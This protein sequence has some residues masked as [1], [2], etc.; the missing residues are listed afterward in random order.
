MQSP[1]AFL[2]LIIPLALVTM[3]SSCE[4]HL[5]SASGCG[6][7]E[8]ASFEVAPGMTTDGTLYLPFH[9]TRNVQVRLPGT[10]DGGS[11]PHQVGVS[12]RLGNCEQ[13]T[14]E[15]R[16]ACLLHV[17]AGLWATPGTYSFNLVGESD[18]LSCT[19]YFTVVVTDL[20]AD[21]GP[22][23]EVHGTVTPNIYWVPQ[24]RSTQ[25][26]VSF[27]SASYILDVLD[28][29]DLDAPQTSVTVRYQAPTGSRDG[30]APDALTITARR[31]A[32]LGTYRFQLAGMAGHVHGTTDV[33]EVHVI[34]P[35]DAAVPELDAAMHDANVEP[36]SDAS[37]D[38][39]MEAGSD[40][41]PSTDASATTHTLSIYDGLAGGSGNVSGDVGGLDCHLYGS[42]VGSGVCEVTLPHGTLI[43]LTATPSGGASVGAWN[44]TGGGT[45]CSGTTCAIVLNND[46][47]VSVGFGQGAVIESFTATPSATASGGSSQLAWS[48]RGVDSCTIEPGTINAVRPSGYQPVYPTDTT[49]YTL[50]CESSAG[51][52][53]ATTTVSIIANDPPVG[54]I[55]TPASNVTIE[56]GDAITFAGNCTDDDAGGSDK[57][58]AWNFGSGADP[59]WAWQ[60]DNNAV[61]YTTV[62]VY[63][64]TYDCTD[65]LGTTNTVQ[66]HVTVTVTAPAFAHVVGSDQHTCGLTISGKIYCWGTNFR[67]QLG[68]PYAVSGSNRPVQVG[69]RDQWVQLDVGSGLSC[70]IDE[71]HAL[72]C[73]G[74]FE[75]G[76][77]I[78]DGIGTGSDAPR[79]IDL[80]TDWQTISVGDSH[81]CAT[82]TNGS[83]HCWGANVYGEVG[84]GDQDQRMTFTQVG[85]D[86]D[87]V[88]VSTGGYL[89]C[90][91]K[92][93]NRAYCWGFNTYYG[94]GD[95]TTM[96]RTS[97][98]EIGS[99]IDWATISASGNF[100]CGTSVTHDLYCWGDDSFGQLGD[101]T[102][103]LPRTSTPTRVGTAS[104]WQSV[105]AGYSHTC[106]LKTSGEILCWGNNAFGQ[107]GRGDHIESPTPLQVESQSDWLSIEANNGHTCGT[108]D[109]GHAYCWGRNSL[110]T[111]G[112]GTTNESTRPTSIQ[113]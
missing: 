27:P 21:A 78:G 76:L 2:L 14:A 5:P 71:L 67:G 37:T 91:I 24:G 13:Q 100:A 44:V 35:L 43:T 55:V 64:V 92:G 58:H 113:P 33:F 70:A 75:G 68:Q 8:P 18:S 10:L 108:R 84:V 63:D 34:S 95:G 40:A 26:R 96:M 23:L 79:Q 66:S 57:T 104:D 17:A 47:S 12:A 31:D 101:G 69:D 82:K 74:Y 52:I 98:T 87:W 90:A 28:V 94:V 62:G 45:T 39:G 7:A 97:P 53:T 73:W 19:Q 83:L 11:M 38:A 1:R 88:H 59:Q 109:G 42:S 20:P 106:A 46:L 80:A 41:S 102:K 105:S 86:T 110:G 103:G 15:Q 81:A 89:S 65:A 6:P 49:T 30:G 36:T 61:R 99:A 25:G 93:G 4:Q 22:P 54:S 48:V 51:T 85:T 77:G 16:N 9:V 111:L 56:V 72:Y 32:T 112:N 50:S 3:G 29:V 60:L 107:L